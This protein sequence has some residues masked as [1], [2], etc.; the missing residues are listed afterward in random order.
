MLNSRISTLSLTAC[1]VVVLVARSGAAGET[2]GLYPSALQYLDK[3]DTRRARSLLA[4]ALKADP[5][6]PARAE[7]EKLLREI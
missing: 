2:A 1:L 4:A 5:R 6:S 7:A 3:G